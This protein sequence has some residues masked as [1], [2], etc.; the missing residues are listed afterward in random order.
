MIMG[1]S[2]EGNRWSVLSLALLLA[3][4][5]CSKGPPKGVISGAITL[6][7]NPVKKGAIRFV[8][9]DGNTTTA[10]GEI[11]DGKYTV[12]APVNMFKVSI[13]AVDNSQQAVA[14]ASISDEEPLAQELIPAKYNV[15]TELVVEIQEGENQKDFVLTSR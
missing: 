2:M 13:N 5:G 4:A 6:D 14:A 15:R 10:G 12:S 11:N 7:G 3:L 1:T 9:I 8:P